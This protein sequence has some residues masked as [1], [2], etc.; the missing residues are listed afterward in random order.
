MLMMFVAHC[1]RS[2]RLL[3]GAAGQSSCGQEASEAPL[4]DI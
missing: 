2:L 1:S 3:G 4:D